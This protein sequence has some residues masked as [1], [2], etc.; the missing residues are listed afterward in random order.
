M[1]RRATWRAVA[2][3]GGAALSLGIATSAAADPIPLERA[4]VREAAKFAS[5]PGSVP[6][7]EN[8]QVLG[9]S[10]LVGGSPHGDV[11][12]FDHAAAGK[13]AYVGT[14]GTPCSG[15]GVKVVDVTDS[16]RPRVVAVAGGYPGS[17]TEDVAVQRIGARD[18]LAVGVQA[19]AS[20]GVNGLALFDVTDPALPRQLS[21][22]GGPNRSVHELD[23]VVR[24]DGRALA[25]LATP[26]N[27]F[28]DVY[29]G[30]N[31]GG[32]FRIVDV[33]NPAG[34]VEVA[35]WGVIADS[36]LPIV[37]GNDEVS[38]S[39]QGVG[40]YA[41]Y[42]AHSARAADGGRTAY[43]SY[44]D[45]GILKFDISD[46]ANPR[47]LGRTTYPLHA[48]GDG[49][50]MTPYDVGGKRY[51][52]QNDEDTDPLS[53]PIVTSSA[54]GTERFTGIEEPWAPTLLSEAG[55]VSGTVH[56]ANDG[57]Q[58]ADFAGSAGKVALADSHDPFYVGIIAGWTVPCPIGDQ[59][60]RA[61]RAG[62]TAFVSNMVSPD[63]AW[64]FL[65]GDAKAVAR[66]AAG[67][68]IVQI[69]DIDELADRVRAA[70]AGGPVTLKLTPSRPEQ[71]HLRVFS[72]A[73]A[74]DADAD[75]VKEYRQ[76]GEFAGLPHVRDDLTPP[77]GTWTI[78][79][80][81]V[82][83]ARAYSSWFSHGIVALDVSDPKRPRKVGQF[84]PDTSKRYSA[85]L[86]VGPTEFWG[87]A[88]DP[89]T[90]VVYGS[91][92]RSGLW[93]LRPSGAAR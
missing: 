78:H 15:G 52:L 18:V 49:H 89:Q 20:N 13:H 48:D 24:G 59:V 16:S 64:P 56:D 50:S 10:P 79:N 19:C 63:D 69:S 84:V 58:D 57:C 80:T 43:V 35:D 30:G 9:Y 87:V 91:D 86:G 83:G 33:T 1:T 75:G 2:A 76:V 46:P 55:A 32:E 73:T 60:V 21:F 3:L 37:A 61:A 4:A 17:S 53:G 81:E 41:A 54:T 22:L 88:I 72:E 7:S 66:A 51:V 28:E 44:W 26:F 31:F 14:W 47:L 34:P 70:M 74:S 5:G 71:G 29:F 36:S 38:S 85:G 23:L 42:Y 82:R 25:L 45:G 40:S 27:E 77:A 68:P 62:A 39:F 65:R 8:F 92:M 6:V 12:F 93:I 67:M 90:G 11:A